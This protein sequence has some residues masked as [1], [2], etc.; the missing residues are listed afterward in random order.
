MTLH[1]RHLPLALLCMLCMA[2]LTGCPDPDGSKTQGLDR[3]EDDPAFMASQS[4]SESERLMVTEKIYFGFDKYDLSPQAQAVLQ[5]KADII[6]SKPN[7][8]VLIEG[9]CDERGTQEYNIALGNRR[10]LAAQRYL[11]NLGVPANQLEAISYGEERPAAQGHNE[12]AWA[13]NRR[14]EF[15]PVHGGIQ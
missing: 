4:L 1:F 11:I 15:N 7:L 10:A 12:N 6:R 8:R 2:M 14:A 13:Q 9:H 3:G 5:R